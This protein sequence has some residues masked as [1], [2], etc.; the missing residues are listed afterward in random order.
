MSTKYDALNNPGYPQT[1]SYLYAARLA[2]LKELAENASITFPP[3]FT[4]KP[5][6]ED[7]LEQEDTSEEAKSISNAVL[8]RGRIANINRN[9]ALL[10]AGYPTLQE[11]E[12]EIGGVNGFFTLFG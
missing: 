5:Q 3:P 6:A 4:D 10:P 8:E 11:L 1:S 2:R 12:T 9:P 7:I